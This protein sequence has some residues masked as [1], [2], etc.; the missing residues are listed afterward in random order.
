MENT[1]YKIITSALKRFEDIEHIYIFNYYANGKKIVNCNVICDVDS[2]IENEELYRGII[3]NLELI[4]T[5]FERTNVILDYSIMTIDQF[6]ED[7]EENETQTYQDYCK[8]SIIYT[9]N[10]SK[11]R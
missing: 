8:S 3:A 11:S 2:V 1:Q 7:M 10:R 9:K 4:R 6:K 5:L